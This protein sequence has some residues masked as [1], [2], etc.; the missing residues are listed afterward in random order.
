M[1]PRF[2]TLSE[3]LEFHEE[4]IRDFGGNP[5]VRD[6]GLAESAVAMPEAGLGGEFFHAFPFEMA[7][8]YAYHIA[9]NHPFIDGNKR[10]AFSSALTFLELN[11]HAVLG[12]EDEL[13][14]AVRKIASGKLDKKEF[15]ALLEKLYHDHKGSVKG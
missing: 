9:Q 7:A 2:L 3:I 10:T 5:G 14:A 13:E 15:A 6:L 1:P 11:G 4:M 8:A 12:G